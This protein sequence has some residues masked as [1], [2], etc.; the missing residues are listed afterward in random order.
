[1]RGFSG[2]ARLDSE[3]QLIRAGTNFVD[4]ESFVNRL[5]IC[6]LDASGKRLVGL[7][8][9]NTELELFDSSLSSKYAKHMRKST[10]Q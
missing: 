3:P 4:F 1:M 8:V 9:T 2:F 5:L 10:A 7:F 6:L